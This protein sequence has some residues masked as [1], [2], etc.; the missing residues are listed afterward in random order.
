MVQR[1]GHLSFPLKASARDFIGHSV[2]ENFD[3]NGPVQLRI[4][5]LVSDAH[6][7]RADLCLNAITTD[8]R[9]R[10]QICIVIPL[11]SHG[12]GDFIHLHVPAMSQK[13]HTSLEKSSLHCAD[14]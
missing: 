12:S 9:A 3:S 8:V 14:D 2:R 7:T 11:V 5:T 1:G 10:P 13:T 4:E 6:A